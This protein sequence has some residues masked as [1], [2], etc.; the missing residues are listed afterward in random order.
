VKEKKK[1]L[2]DKLINNNFINFEKKETS[3]GATVS[4]LKTSFEHKS[5]F[6][7]VKFATSFN[8]KI[9]GQLNPGF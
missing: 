3:A 1:K 4:F 7:T 8:P 6:V 5:Q 2:N 9:T